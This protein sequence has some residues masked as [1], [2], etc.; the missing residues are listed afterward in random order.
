[1]TVLPR[2]LREA[3]STE[4]ARKRWAA[5]L[6]ELVAAATERWRLV[7]GPPFEPGGSTAWVAP[8]TGPDGACVLKVLYPHP[9]GAH[10]A[11][12]LRVWNGHGAVRLLDT[13]VDAS[14]PVLLL[15]R[16]MPGTTLRARP[17]TEQDAVVAELLRRLW[18]APVDPGAFPT[19][20]HMCDQW[21]DRFESNEP[22]PI[23]VVLV[24]AGLELFRELPSTAT[25]SALLCTDLHAGNVLAAEREPWLMIDPKPHVGDTTYDAL[26]HMLNCPSRLHADPRGLCER[27]AELLHLDGER[28]RLW[29]FARCVVEAPGWPG[30][31]ELV[32]RLAP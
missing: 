11:E 12:G 9:E 2:H 10:E 4:P 30:L 3:C 22:P 16:C 25:N 24:R 7:V 28:L 21:A 15:E 5:R 23:D 14:V 19:L 27:M 32:P 1:M 20:Q 8:A 6:P 29:L 13:V 31:A 26:Q 17:E 18:V